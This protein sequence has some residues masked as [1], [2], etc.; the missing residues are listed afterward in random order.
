MAVQAVTEHDLTGCE[1]FTVETPDGPIGWIEEV[2]LGSHD[3]PRALAV[4]IDG[5]RGLLDAH[6]VKAVVPER[7]WVVVPSRPSLLELDAPRLEAADDAGDSRLVASWATT[8]TA[9]P[10]P[11]APG[12]SR[13]RRLAGVRRA[14][15]AHR[16][17]VADQVVWQAVALLYVGIFAIVTTVIT[18]AFFVSYLVAGRAY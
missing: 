15:P 12:K 6:D 8:G 3:E 17:D 5:R 14:Q 11:A 10:P 9:L 4:R 16:H 18:L 1:G 13:R 2:W 7:R